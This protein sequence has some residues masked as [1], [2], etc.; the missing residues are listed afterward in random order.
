MFTY[1]SIESVTKLLD[2]WQNHSKQVN[3]SKKLTQDDRYL[4]KAKEINSPKF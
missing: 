3:G 4:L 2:G 1:I